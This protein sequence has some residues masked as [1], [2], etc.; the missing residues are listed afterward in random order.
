MTLEDLSIMRFRPFTLARALLLFSLVEFLVAL[1]SRAQPIATL[2]TPESCWVPGKVAGFSETQLTL[3][4]ACE[5]T[6][7]T[8]A[9][10]INSNSKIAGPIVVGAHT[11]VEY[12]TAGEQLI[13]TH[14]AA[15]PV[16][17]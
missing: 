5:Q 15:P 9:F 2:N 6:R 7:N 11:T 4:I 1:P 3:S 16:R 8:L 13:A 14:V 17:E 10:L 12:R